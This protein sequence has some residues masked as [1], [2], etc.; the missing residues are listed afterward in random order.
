MRPL[1]RSGGKTIQGPSLLSDKRTYTA[2]A[3]QTIFAVNYEGSNVDV[4]VNGFRLAPDD[5]VATGGTSVSLVLSCDAGDIVTL[6]G[7]AAGVVPDTYSKSEMDSLLAGKAAASHVHDT[8]QVTGLD[9]ALSG[10]A[11]LRATSTI[12]GGVRA[13]L[14]GSTLYITN[15]GSDA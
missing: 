5:Y 8:S 2:T 3:G 13:R 12:D 6:C 14:A 9:A 7:G 1:I 10:K 4:Y 11:A 15:N